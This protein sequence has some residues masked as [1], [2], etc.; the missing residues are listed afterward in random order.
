MNHLLTIEE[1]TSRLKITVKTM[2]EWLRTG[3]LPGVKT[4]K[5]WRVR[6]QDIEAFVKSRL[7]LAPE[8]IGEEPSGTT[9]RTPFTA[10]PRESLPAEDILVALVRALLPEGE[11]RYL[12]DLGITTFPLGQVDAI[13]ERHGLTVRVVR[14][15]DPHRLVACTMP[16]DRVESYGLFELRTLN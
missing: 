1:A 3:K 8:P 7:R 16:G 6:E 14:G 11:P 10:T 13:L 5:Y 2:R 15:N 9:A 12:R 4:G